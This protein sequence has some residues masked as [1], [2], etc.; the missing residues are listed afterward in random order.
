MDLSVCII[1]R[2]EEGSLPGCIE[3][4]QDVADEIIVVDTGSADATVEVARHMGCRVFSFSWN[5]NFA[6]ARNHALEQ[7]RGQWILSIDA[8]ERLQNP[9]SVRQTLQ[10]AVAETGGFL[11]HCISPAENGGKAAVLLLRLFRRHPRIRFRGRI[12]EQ[13]TVAEAGFHIKTSTIV[14][15]HEGYAR[16]KQ[17]LQAKHTRNL[18]LI[19]LALAED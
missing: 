18:R 10:G 1:A 15:W 13:V 12:H 2:D 19:E 14:L 3:S 8:D 17:V 6:A 11:L 4:V 9:E 5:D 7:A 16:G